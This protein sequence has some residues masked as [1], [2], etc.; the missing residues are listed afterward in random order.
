MAQDSLQ[1]SVQQIG[2]ERRRFLEIVRD[3]SETIGAEFFSTLVKHLRRTLG[4]GC[5]YVCEFV[6]RQ[7]E[8]A[9]TLAACMEDD[10]METFEFPV[11]AQ[12]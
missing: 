5:V 6:G 8:R 4:A 9:R 2:D 3:V 1:K 10:R 7:N 11:G 12:S